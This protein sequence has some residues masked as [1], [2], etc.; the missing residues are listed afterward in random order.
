MILK[1]CGGDDDYLLKK[2]SLFSNHHQ[3][4]GN[5]FALENLVLK[6]IIPHQHSLFKQ[7]SLPFCANI[8]SFWIHM[9]ELVENA[10]FNQVFLSMA[11]CGF[12]PPQLQFH[13][14]NLIL[15]E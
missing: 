13:F 12:H 15:A 9:K 10:V 1:L 5:P 8:P 11:E 3:S 14:L 4:Y 6:Y 7:V 2:K